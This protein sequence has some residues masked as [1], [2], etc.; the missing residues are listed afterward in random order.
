MTER[1]KHQIPPT[2][3]T[4]RRRERERKKGR[5][6]KGIKAHRVNNVSITISTTEP[7][8]NTRQ[9][10]GVT[11]DT[12]CLCPPSQQLPPPLGLSLTSSSHLKIN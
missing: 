2:A 3:H 4:H 5:G 6:G 10:N 8:H 9:L 1:S 7:R 12:A 11:P